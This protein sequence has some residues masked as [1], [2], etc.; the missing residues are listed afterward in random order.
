MKR[1]ITFVGAVLLLGWVALVRADGPT[2]PAT[3]SEKDYSLKTLTSLAQALPRPLPGFE[4]RGA[5]P[6]APF[7]RVTPGCEA[8]P[9]RVEYSVEWVNPELGAR[10]RSEEAAAV[11][12]A[13]SRIN[14]P[15]SQ[16]QQ[17]DFAARMDELAKQLGLAIQK[18]N[19]AE[20]ARLQK[21]MEKLGQELASVG[22]AQNDIIANETRSLTKMSGLSIRLVVNDFQDEQPLRLVKEIAPVGG[23]PAY[24]FHDAEGTFTD[25]V[26]VLVGP[27]KRA[28][29]NGQAVYEAARKNLPHTRAQTVTVTVTGDPSLTAKVV[30]ATDWQAL[31]ALVR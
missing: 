30:A 4:A 14:T 17:K 16:A 13:A 24:A 7:D 22:Q 18:G 21:E 12:R 27:W 23:N 3:Q 9:L 25:R 5:S 19:Q 29:R 1:T 8:Y 15:S 10:E 6:V 28:V 31:Q 20:V 11:E 2:R 26:V